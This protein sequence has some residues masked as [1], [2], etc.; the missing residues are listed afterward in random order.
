MSS[1]LH[2]NCTFLFQADE[3]ME[4]KIKEDENSGV[5]WIDIEKVYEITNEPHMVPIYKKLN[6]KLKE[7]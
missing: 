7:I 2:L 1:H 4:L 3:D 5:Q 6:E